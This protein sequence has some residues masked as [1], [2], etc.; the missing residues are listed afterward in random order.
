LHA[1]RRRWVCAVALAGV[2]CSGCRNS[3][4]STTSSAKR[5]GEGAG[6]HR[7]LGLGGAAVQGGRRQGLSGGS[8]L[9]SWRRS[10][11][12]FCGFLGSTGRL[13]VFLRRCYWGQEGR[14][15]TSGEG[16]RW[17]SKLPAAVLGC[18]SDDCWRGGRGWRPREASWRRGEAAVG[19]GRG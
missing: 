12:G 9:S 15:T 10:R 17:R 19:F 11:Q 14:G 4:R 8:A 6:A 7:G 3:L 18:N 13:V 1:Q 2:W 5:I 16:S